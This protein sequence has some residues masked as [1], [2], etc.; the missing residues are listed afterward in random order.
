MKNNITK[1]FEEVNL[2]EKIDFDLYT[3]VDDKYSIISNENLLKIIKY[4]N[5]LKEE[6]LITDCIFCEGRFPFEISFSC[7]D[8]DGNSKDLYVGKFELSNGKLNDLFIDFN[9][10]IYLEDY[11][12]VNSSIEFQVKY[13]DYVFRCS[14]EHEH[15]YRMNLVL[16]IDKGKLSIIKIGQFPESTLL[17]E[18]LS[19]YYKKVLRKFN[20][21]YVDY[22]NAEKSFKYGLY[23]GAYGY[24]R[25]VFENMI[26]Y[27][28]KI[29]N[30]Q[31]EQNANAKSKL[32]SVKN[33][34]DD[35]I[36]D[37][38]YP[39]YSALSAGIHTMNESECKENYDHLKTIIDIQLQHVKSKDELNMKLEESAKK[40]EE[41][42]KKY[43]K[44][45]L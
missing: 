28:L 14:N 20:D 22:K 25:R 35:Q 38:L 23:S 26:N 36:Q 32:N 16:F 4:L 21:S 10:P 8:F 18:Y 24:L 5:V 31:L 12:I 43:S 9:N 45:N 27:Y 39:L 41:L 11:K 13:F 19:D 17:G 2:Y 33:Y 30:A 7:K 3:K 44:R 6:K 40:L 34:F 37:L 15:I 29:S 42:Q 1:L